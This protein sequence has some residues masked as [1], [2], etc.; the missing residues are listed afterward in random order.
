M[1]AA[2]QL[3]DRMDNLT[4]NLGQSCELEQYILEV[5]WEVAV[6]EAGTPFLAK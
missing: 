1:I 2:Y 3:V 5:L 6:L 4:T